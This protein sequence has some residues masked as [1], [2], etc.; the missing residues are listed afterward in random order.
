MSLHNECVQPQR[1]PGLPCPARVEQEG[2]AA[3]DGVPPVLSPHYRSG[4]VTGWS[5]QQR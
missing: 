2:M 4:L 1:P 5:S 3:A